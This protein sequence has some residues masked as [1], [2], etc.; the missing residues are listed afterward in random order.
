[1]NVYNH[2]FN[3]QAHHRATGKDLFS[4]SVSY[5]FE[6]SPRAS[7]GCFKLH[8]LIQIINSILK[9]NTCEIT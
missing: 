9:I 3:W 7:E 8:I 5:N 6:A 2:E 1:M 4:V